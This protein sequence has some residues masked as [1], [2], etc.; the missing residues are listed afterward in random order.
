MPSLNGKLPLW[1]IS[2]FIKQEF[3]EDYLIDPILPAGGIGLLHGKGGHGKTQFVLTLLNE[4]ARGGNLFGKYP[5]QKGK[6]ILF[7]FDMPDPILK[8]R[9]ARAMPAIAHPENILVVPY[10]K[11]INLLDPVRDYA[12]QIAG[13]IEE[14]QPVLA[15]FDTLRKLHPYDE[16]DNAVPS[17]VYGKLNEIC[18]GAAAFVLH[19]DRKASLQK[20]GD[21]AAED[22]RESFRGA[23]A[24]V[25]DADLGM[26]LRKRGMSVM[27]DY[28]KQRCE[29]QP[30][31][32]LQMNPE[33]LL[34]EPRPPQS[35]Q[36]WARL[37]LV[38]EPG[39]DKEGL[40]KA[41]MIRGGVGKSV[42]YEA[43]RKVL[44]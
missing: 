24:W 38:E 9:L 32:L 7:E 39:I 20:G 42:A 41:V 15:V 23:R 3:A 44:D 19:H 2:S 31:L 21:E 13:M 5:V 36:E 6:V 40:A 29:E 25:D 16:N 4:V 30:N 35:A 34:L 43:V 17:Q 11:P 33:T 14:H 22:A 12:K 26:R 10:H 37:I 18:G 8:G 1:S 27:V 28:S